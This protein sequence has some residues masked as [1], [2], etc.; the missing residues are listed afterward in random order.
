MPDARDPSLCGEDME[1][2]G[3]GACCMLTALRGIYRQCIGAGVEAAR[4]V[5][6][7]R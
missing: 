7:A 2:A 5:D 3:H 4:S 1:T 6:M